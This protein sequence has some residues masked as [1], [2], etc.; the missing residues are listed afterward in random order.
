MPM[1]KLRIEQLVLDNDNPRITRS[2]SQHQALQKIIRDQKTKLVRLA[3]SIVDRGLSPIERL[4]VLE[5][6]ANPKRYIAIEGN[7]RVAALRLL[8]NPS[9]MTGL[10]MPDGMQKALES[11]AKVFD[12]SKVEPIECYEVPSRE[13]GRYWIELR[14]N[15]EDQGRGVVS[16]KPIVAAR[17]RN[18]DP[19]IQAF[20]MVIE[21]GGFSEDEAEAIRSGFPLT[22]LQRL[23]ETP[24][25]RS[26]LGL[27][28]KS[29]SLH[30][31]LPAAELIKPLKKIVLDL[32][33][34]K[35]GTSRK[36]NKKEQM[37]DYI[38]DLGK[39]DKPDLSKATGVERPI[40][41]L[42]KSEFTKS[43]RKA[44]ARKLPPNPADRKQIVPKSCSV[45]VT[46]NRIAEIYKELRALKL[47]DARNA[48]AVLLR[49]FLELSVDHFLERNKVSLESKDPKSGKTFF[50]SLDKKLEES[51]DILVKAGATR[52][53]FASIMRS[54][55]VKSSPLNTDLLHSY[56]HDRR[57]TPSPQ[58]LT[59]AWNNAENLFEKI[60]P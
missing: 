38:N 9:A 22:T 50:K 41:S 19:A 5:V 31:T 32:A 18:R 55:S 56:I 24:D 14:H 34:P 35:G 16:W 30:T 53:E 40:E 6:S 45:N 27:T 52:K 36:L 3:R 13:E 4:M 7:R 59:A 33:D 25:V 51:V 54:L 44:P 48:I 57:S 60:W 12:K 21:H 10:E 26:M 37:V 58:E 28:L 29:G 43:S 11:L 39:S 8:T 49:V 46:D 47:A 1:I 15:G 42:Q 2:E 17:W 20:D 23:M